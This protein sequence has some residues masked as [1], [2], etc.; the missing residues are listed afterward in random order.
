MQLDDRL[1]ETKPEITNKA[2]FTA[3]TSLCYSQALKVSSSTLETWGGDIGL[4]TL[5]ALNP[6]PPNLRATKSLPLAE[7]AI[8]PAW[9]PC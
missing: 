1:L 7:T 4:E 8:Y 2:E 3:F 5:R 9:R 6:I